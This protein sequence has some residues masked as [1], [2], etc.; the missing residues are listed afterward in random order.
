MIPML[1]VRAGDFRV[2]ARFLWQLPRF[3]RRPIGLSEARAL[4]R[5]RL[6]NRESDFL[7]IAR[8]AIYPH[9]HSPYF[10]LLQLAGCEY[11][12]LETLVRREGLEGALRALRGKGVYLTVDE[13]KARASVVRGSASFTLHPDAL[14]NPISTTYVPPSRKSDHGRERSPVPA[15][16][17][18]IVDTCVRSLIFQAFGGLDWRHGFWGVPGGAVIGEILEYGCVGLHVCRWFT[19]IDPAS[20][21]LHP[22]Y[23]WS[24]RALGWGSSLAG[25]RL[26][27]PQHIPLHDPMPIIHWLRGTLEKGRTPHLRTSSSSAVRLCQ[28]ASESG[29]E[30][31]GTHFTV[32]GEPLTPHRLAVI[33]KAGGQAHPL[34]GSSEAGH[35]GIACTKPERPDDVH[36]LSDFNAVVQPPMDEKADDL[37]ANTLLLTS[38][39]PSASVLLLNV[40]LGDRAVVERRNC[41]CPMETLGWTTHIHTIRSYEKLTAAGINFLDADIVSVLEELLPKRFGGKPTDYQLIEEEDHRGN[42]RIKLLVHPAVGPVDTDL[43]SEAFLNA[44]SPGSGAERV[45]GLLWRDAGLL[46]VER[47]APLTTSSGKILHL[48]RTRTTS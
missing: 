26:P 46:R 15:N 27:R 25:V 30:L 24:A 13:A 42:P 22:R 10:K 12:D 44:I 17:E 8:E 34:F 16:L 18:N 6:E 43:V 20:P 2:G 19:Q 29:I 14:R 48:H 45:M 7:K 41:G 36:L 32:G 11:G 1:N 4:L 37:P 47:R 38:L 35:I 21:A 28:R 33:R 5:W 31:A 3:L 9:R 39:R 23:H 40:S